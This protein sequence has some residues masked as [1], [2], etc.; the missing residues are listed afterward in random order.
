MYL[1]SLLLLPVLA[2]LCGLFFTKGRINWKEFAV[3]ETAVFL[4]LLMGY[5]IA[6]YRSTADTEI[7]S[8][9]I[10]QKQMQRVS[11]SHSYPC[12]CRT[13]SCGK[14]CSSVVCDTCY[15]HPYDQDWNVWTTNGEGMSIDR[16]D[17]Q[18]LRE[19]PRWTSAYVGEPTA[20]A[21]YFENYVKANPASILRRMGLTQGY[22][23]W[24]PPYPSKVYDYYRV[25]R[26]F[27]EGFNARD[28]KDWNWLLNQLNADLGAK[29]KVNIIVGLVKN[30]NPEYAYALEEAW[31]GGKKNDAIILI[32]V[33]EYPKIGWVRIISWTK[34]ED[35]RV[36]LR[37]EIQD[38]GTVQKRDAIIAAIR[39]HVD[40]E[41][42]HRKF[43]ELKYLAAS[44][45]PGTTGTIILFLLGCAL[46]AGLMWFF[47]NEDPFESRPYGGYYARY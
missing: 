23:Q 12:N 13:V 16:V 17:S 10:A 21:H 32:G 2:G 14:D 7:W 47:Y 31:I 22:Q 41:F 24:L 36:Y 43:D 44:V 35:F 39:K 46:Q 1:M 8:G 18:G 11:C 38:I 15:L 34:A 19:P 3:M 9:R 6:T 27:S 26:F 29:K 42:V 40:E 5:G 4:V 25:D 28:A 33:P 30:P 20:V 45:Q 37:D